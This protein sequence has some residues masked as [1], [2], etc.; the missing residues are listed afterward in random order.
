LPM[1]FVQKVGPCGFLAGAILVT[2]GIVC[3]NRIIKKLLTQLCNGSI[4]EKLDETYFRLSSDY[5][6]ACRYFVFEYRKV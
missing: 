3:K 5:L 6:A 2:A 1:K 4:Q